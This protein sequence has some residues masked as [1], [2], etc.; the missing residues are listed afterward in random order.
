MQS[1]DVDA[2]CQ[3][4]SVATYRLSDEVLLHCVR[5]FCKQPAKQ[6]KCKFSG[7]LIRISTA[8]VHWCYESKHKRC[9]IILPR[10]TVPPKQKVLVGTPKL[11]HGLSGT[12]SAEFRK[13]LIC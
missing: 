9:V 13:G 12:L 10:L 1:I 4:S 8:C 11:G 3:C 5:M 6:L 7:L 2:S